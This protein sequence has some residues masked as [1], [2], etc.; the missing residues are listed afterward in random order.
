MTLDDPAPGPFPG[1]RR[2]RERQ[3]EA[4]AML[5]GLIEAARIIPPALRAAPGTLPLVVISGFLGAGKTTLLNRLLTEPHGR[6]LAV[7]V[8]DFGRIDV[9]AALI[10]AAGEDAIALPN[11]C[12]CCSVAG[13]LTR[14]LVQLAQRAEPPEAIV[15][16]ASGLADPHGIAQ[17]ALANPALRLDG[18]LTVVDAETVGRHAADPDCHDTFLAQLAAADLLL[19][20]KT[21]LVDEA[22]RAGAAE[23]LGRLAPGRPVLTVE[24]G[25]VPVDVV[26]GLGGR[27]RPSW[28]AATSGHADPFR[29]WEGE[30]LVPLDRARVEAM[31]AS[32]PPGVLRAKG[33][34]CLSEDPGVR[35]LLQKVGPRW[36][37]RPAGTWTEAPRSAVVVIGTA[38]AID[39]AGLRRS[40]EAC[41]A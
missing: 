32:L 40:W 41:Q 11:G 17:V 2:D 38:G 26:L 35:A 4:W 7:L 5:S 39:P 3:A 20:S 30:S 14:T 19:L 34:L 1:T 36:S 8:N 33:F 15:L 12:V 31:V 24:H 27:A 9:D 13:D 37:L 6:R 28:P 16:E 23:Q 18:V 10:R 29:S 21:D 25:S 22:G